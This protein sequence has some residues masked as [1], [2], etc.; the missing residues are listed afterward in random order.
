MRFHMTAGFYVILFS[1][2]YRLSRVQWA[3]VILL[4]ACVMVAE[5]FNTCL[6]ELCNLNA[7]SYDPLVKLAKDIAAGAVLLLSLAALAVAF[8]FYFDL[9]V[10][11]AIAAFFLSRPILLAL[12][13]LS[14]VA[15]ALFIV[16]GPNGI[17]RIYRKI[18]AG[19]GRRS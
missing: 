14:F 12:L 16:F 13:V 3:V 15:A 8:L 11:T 5:T 19:A 4:I 1:F 2:F 18:K 17:L 9:E 10:I 6:E 7:Q